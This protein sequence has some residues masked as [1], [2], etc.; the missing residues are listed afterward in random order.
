[1]GE[2]SKSLSNMKINLTKARQQGGIVGIVVGGLALILGVFV[3]A[4]VISAM[5][6]IWWPDPNRGPT[7]I[8]Q[9][10]EIENPEASPPMDQEEVDQ[11]AEDLG[12]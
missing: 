11:E 6:S 7:P 4:K 1:M 5:V 12:D 2:P 3:V 9:K 10:Q 8:Q